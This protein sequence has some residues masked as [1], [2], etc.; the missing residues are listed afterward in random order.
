MQKKIKKETLIIAELGTSHGGDR[1]KALELVDAAAESGADCVKCQIVFADEIL[2]PRTG[3]VS[4]PGGEIPLYQV[5]K[6][7]ERGPDF[8]G[9]I[10]IQAE[11]RGLLFLATP[12]GLKSA[13]LLREMQ[14]RS[15]KI[16][17]PELNFTAL[18]EE[19]ASWGVPMYLSSGVSTLGIIEDALHTIGAVFPAPPAD[20]EFCPVSLLHCVTAYPAPP[21][22]YNLRV[23]SN[24]AGIFGVPVGLSDHTAD[25]LLVPVLAAALGAPVIEKHFCLSRKDPGLDD[26]LALEPAD[27]LVMVK[28]V[29][30]AAGME[31]AAVIEEL[32]AQFGPLV[33]RTLGTGVKTLAPSEQANYGRTNRSIHAL[34]DIQPGERISPGMIGVL[35][36]EK[37]L[38]PGLSPRW[39]GQI[40]GRRAR[41]FIP[42]GEG[43][44]FEDI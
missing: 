19:T 29:R 21:E 25:P 16:A 41:R 35:R 5:F 9:D 1:T 12:F 37:L 24:L 23:L 36:T 6:N 40:A 34:R 20:P 4:L 13:G 22:D 26:M 30:R 43:I 8:Y 10:K 15:V 32:T 42:A 2:H 3:T 7:L 31:P 17:S 38:R 11:K 14:P 44:Q 27:F 28:G 18:L 33:D 39:E